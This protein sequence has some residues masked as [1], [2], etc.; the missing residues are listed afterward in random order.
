MKGKDSGMQMHAGMEGGYEKLNKWLRLCDFASVVSL[1]MDTYD[2]Q[3]P[4]TCS[5]LGPV[6]PTN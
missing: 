5:P 4:P 6:G 2:A 3:P 1:L